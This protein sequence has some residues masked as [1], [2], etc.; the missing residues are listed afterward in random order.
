M[1]TATPL[2]EGLA[3]TASTFVSL[4]VIPKSFPVGSAFMT[5]LLWGYEL[6]IL[7]DI[8]SQFSVESNSRLLL[9]CLLRSMMARTRFSARA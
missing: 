1:I 5:S 8:V 6:H 9:F 3:G 7:S 4:V 2:G